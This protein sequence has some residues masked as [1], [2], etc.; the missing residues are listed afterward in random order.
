MKRMKRTVILFLAFV[1]L[2]VTGLILYNNYRYRVLSSVI[3]FNEASYNIIILH[4]NIGQYQEFP[5]RDLDFRSL[6]PF[7]DSTP[8]VY[9]LSIRGS[10]SEV[11]LSD[12]TSEYILATLLNLR[13]RP[14]ITLFRSSE[15]FFRD[16]NI[17]LR[18]LLDFVLWG[19]CDWE[20]FNYRVEIALLHDN[21]MVVKRF[22][23]FDPSRVI[24]D[25]IFTISHDNAD[26]LWEFH[27]IL[28]EYFDN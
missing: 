16:S 10:D 22:L 12:T 2:I 4:S 8:F 1:S 11:V 25:E 19:G 17:E 23:G 27:Q 20:D 18:P 15:Y 14:T 7:R 24:R 26:I 6:R 5:P 21:R 3:G 13:V 28:L 9:P